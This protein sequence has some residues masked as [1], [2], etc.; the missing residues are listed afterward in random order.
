M[1]LR[2]VTNVTPP[3]RVARAASLDKGPYTP[4]GRHFTSVGAE[5]ATLRGAAKM[6]L[7]LLQSHKAAVTE[8]EQ[9]RALCAFLGGFC[10]EV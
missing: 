1:E 9:R 2:E 7:S 6:L 3:L 4:G 5:E 8:A 10:G